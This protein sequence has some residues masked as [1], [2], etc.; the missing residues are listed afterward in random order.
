[1]Q[2]FTSGNTAIRLR[3][4][5]PASA[6]PRPAILLLHGAGGNV[7]QW[8]D[9]LAPPL[10]AAGIALYAPHYFDRTATAF[11]DTATILDGEHV[12]LWLETVRDTLTYISERPAADPSRIALLGISLGAFIS[13]ALGTEAAQPIK[14]IVELSGG[15]V[16]PWDA[17]VTPNF[18]PTLI[19]HGEADKVV[20][21][22]E[23]HKVDRI[24]TEHQVPHQTQLFAAEDHWFS[25]AAQIRIVTL[26][27]DFLAAYL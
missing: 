4:S 25:T 24:L 7:D 15:L 19:L 22:A 20:P 16:S 26:V 13:L 1:M 14:A 2:T 17:R 9:R 27:S 8:F 23:A 11:A 21:V 12:P 18:P 6:T 5:E 3:Q 10:A